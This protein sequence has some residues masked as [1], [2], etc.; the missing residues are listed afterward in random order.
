MGYWRLLAGDARHAIFL[1]CLVDYSF[2]NTLIWAGKRWMQLSGKVP[3]KLLDMVALSWLMKMTL[4]VSTGFSYI[5]SS[6]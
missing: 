6:I 3:D 5:S 4:R 1:I 2:V